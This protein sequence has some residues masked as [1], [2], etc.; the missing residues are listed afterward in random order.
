MESIEEKHNFLLNRKEI[1]MNI[2]LKSPPNMASAR[3]MVSEKFSA[4]EENVHISKIAGKFGSEGFTILANI[5]TS[6]SEKDRFHL[7]NK[8][9]KKESA[10]AKK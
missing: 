8:K 6:A 9:Q 4:P 5:Y 2:D 7:I 1:K 3:T 10:P